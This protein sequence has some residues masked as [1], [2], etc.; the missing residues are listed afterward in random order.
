MRIE[1]TL[2][3]GTEK[4]EPDNP[5]QIYYCG[6]TVSDSPHLGHARG[7]VHTDVFKRFLQYRGYEV[8]HV[9]NITDVNEKIFNRLAEEG[10]DEESEQ[11]LAD[12]FAR[13]VLNS[14][15]RL[16][17]RRA[18]VYPRVS[19]HISEIIDLVESLVDSGHAYESNGS[20][21]FDVDEF[22]GYGDL[23]NQSLEDIE[24]QGD[25]K[26][27]SDKDS[28]HDFALWKSV[29]P[30]KTRG[31]VWDSPW[32]HGRPGWHIECSAM[33]STHLE[34]PIDVHIGGQDLVFPHHENEIAQ[35]ESAEGTKF[36]DNWMHIRL[37]N[38]VED[39][40][41]MSSSRDN[42]KTVDSAIDEYGANAVRWF[43]LSSNYD[44][45]QLYSED[46]IEQSKSKWNNVRKTYEMLNES[47]GESKSDATQEHRELR[48]QFSDHKEQ[49]EEFLSDNLN[50]RK[51]LNRIEQISGLAQNYLKDSEEYDQ[52]LIIDMIS[53]Y[54]DTLQEVFGFS[55]EEQEDSD[56]GV[57]DSMIDY[58]DE[59]RDSSEFEKADVIRNALN[60]A[61]YE[62]EDTSE[63]TVVVDADTS[64]E[65]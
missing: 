10:I 15:G 52:G 49:I 5:V 2:S 6:L 27:I 16:N 7:W 57:V 40:E 14:M 35:S 25:S 60:E 43:L 36:A 23:S 20:V 61:G 56:A 58:R 31:D 42:F 59:L 39:S 65:P 29:N 41:K 18:D 64:R 12:R 55:L 1:N 44:S 48:S 4:L 47:L 34:L 21:Y 32:G 8:R 19:N 13:E 11:E 24:S 17:L 45:E 51:S 30:N 9:E 46:K 50:T 53:F 63:G 22:E 38:S 26:E 3:D 37:L 54:E 28:E 62:I 33:S